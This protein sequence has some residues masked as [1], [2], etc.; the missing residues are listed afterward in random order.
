MMIRSRPGVVAGTAS[1]A[2][3]DTPPRKPAHAGA[4][5]ASHRSAQ[6]LL[7]PLVD[8]PDHI[9]HGVTPQQPRAD[10]HRADQQRLADRIRERVRD[11]TLDRTAQRQP[12]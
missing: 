4:A 6:P 11:Q 3:S 1:A 5:G 7:R 8:G 2:A 10:H 12:R 9:G